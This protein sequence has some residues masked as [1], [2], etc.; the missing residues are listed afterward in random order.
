MLRVGLLG[1]AKIAPSAIVAPA[2]SVPEVSL[3]AVAAR[4]PERAKAFAT[5]HGIPRVIASYAAMIA[6]PEIDALYIPLPNGL[7]GKWVIAAA[8]AGTHVLCEKPIAANADEVATMADAARKAGRVLM[9]A[10]HWRYHPLAAR[11]I[12]IVQSGELGEIRHI[13]TSM[14]FPLPLL[15][16]IRYNFSLAGGAMMD[17]GCYAVHMARALGGPDPEVVSAEAKLRDPNV[18]RAMEAQLRFKSGATGSV[19][20]SMWS[21]KLL[22]ISAHVTGSLGE[23]HVFNPVMP[24]TYLYQLEAFAKACLHG[25]PVLTSAEDGIVNMSVI[26]AIYRAAGMQVRDPAA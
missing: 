26:D 25:G 6:D 4:D 17:A 2:K 5:K 20:V 19:S 23:M 10:F 3:V 15:G 7:H 16:D 9:E 13:R 1:A 21:W 11:M 12:E 24:P 18:D 8:E 22:D 14:C